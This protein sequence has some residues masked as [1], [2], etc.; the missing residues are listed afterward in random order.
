MTAKT[1]TTTATAANPSRV[2]EL[3]LAL[4]GTDPKVWR[5]IQVREFTSLLELH[6]IIQCS[7]GWEDSHCHKFNFP[8]STGDDDDD[9]DDDDSYDQFDP[10]TTSRKEAKQTLS[11]V[12]TGE[13]FRFLYTYDFGD[14]WEH[15]LE[16]TKILPRG[17][18]NGTYPIC[19]AGENAWRRLS[20]STYTQF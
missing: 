16:V 19:V 4:L 10:M 15:G 5:R 1:T 18:A 9:D 14:N 11:Q 12:V 8:R 2:F 17:D 3:E 7:M 6:D 20:L 13:T